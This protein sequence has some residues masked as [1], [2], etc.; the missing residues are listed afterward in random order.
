MLL[1]GLVAL[2]SV[3]AVLGSWRRY[4]A[5]SLLDTLVAGR[6]AAPHNGETHQNQ[7]A[8]GPERA[9]LRSGRL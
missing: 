1:V 4:M 6:T 7:A 9:G 8:R 5:R 3:P 2:F